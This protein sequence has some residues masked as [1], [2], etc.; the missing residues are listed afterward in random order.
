[1]KVK[2]NQMVKL[3]NQQKQLVIV[4]IFFFKLFYIFIFNILGNDPNQ[5]QKDTVAT[6]IDS[7]CYLKIIFFI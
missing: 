5:L 2:M 4:K 6:T 3:N 1:M 7:L